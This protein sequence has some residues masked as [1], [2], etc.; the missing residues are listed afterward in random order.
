MERRVIHTERVSLVPSVVEHAD[1]LWRV[2]EVSLPELR[3]WMAWAIDD[4]YE[5][6]RDFL[7]MCETM[8]QRAEAWTFT[9]FVGGDAVGTVGLAS[10]Q[11][12][13]SCAELGY[14]I[15]TDLAGRGLMTEAGAATV[16]FGFDDLRLHRLELH[17]GLR[18][19]ASI[20]VAEKLGFQRAGVLRDGS[21]GEDGWYDCHVFDLL[22]TDERL[23]RS[24]E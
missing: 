17:A 7:T 16:R 12:L 13:I 2:V 14:W 20:R 3:P 10:Y 5:H 11:P 6:N 15:R 23:P 24:P 22:E 4:S 21:R 18:N 8:W 19:A 1:S 9:L